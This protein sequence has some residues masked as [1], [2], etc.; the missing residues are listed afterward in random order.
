MEDMKKL[1][2][3]INTNLGRIG[4][5]SPDFMKAFSGLMQTVEK[6]G[7]VDTK[8]KELISI[9][10]SVSKQ[11]KWCIALHVKKALSIGITREEIMESCQVAVLMGGGPSLMYVQSVIKAID[12][13]SE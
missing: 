8:T 5:E 3:E 7:A 9:A 6:P 11:C 1:T 12:E 13:F 2:E 10:L 4:Q